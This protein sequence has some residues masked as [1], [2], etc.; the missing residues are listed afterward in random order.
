MVVHNPDLEEETVL[1]AGQEVKPQ[2]AGAE[3]HKVQSEQKHSLD[4]VEMAQT[5]LAFALSARRMGLRNV[6]NAFRP[7][8][9]MLH[10]FGRY[11]TDYS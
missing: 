1:V 8:P 4:Q 5:H 2:V 10:N 3:L 6:G 11:G 9:V 7:E